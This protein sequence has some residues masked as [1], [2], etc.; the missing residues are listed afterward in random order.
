[1]IYNNTICHIREC[2][3]ICIQT[4]CYWVHSMVSSLPN[5][6]GGHFLGSFS[7]SAGMSGHGSSCT[8]LRRLFCNLLCPG[9]IVSPTV[10]SLTLYFLTCGI[11]FSFTQWCSKA[12]FSS[13][14]PGIFPTDNINPTDH[15]SGGICRNSL[16]GA[17]LMDNK[18][19]THNWRW[20]ANVTFCVHSQLC[21]VGWE[22][23]LYK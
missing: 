11:S 15:R 8:P 13:Q 12:T 6:S 21:F 20:A 2:V 22:N 19:A 5:S 16:L 17:Q 23:T 3:Y 1:M 18:L 10:T 14:A 9:L 7:S 4:Q